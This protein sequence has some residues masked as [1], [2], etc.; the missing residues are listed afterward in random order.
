MFFQILCRHILHIADQVGS[1]LSQ[2]IGTYLHVCEHHSRN[3]QK[4]FLPLLL[5]LHFFRE[6]SQ[7]NLHIQD[8]RYCGQWYEAVLPYPGSSKLVPYGFFIHLQKLRDPL[9]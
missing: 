9:Q 8:L 2:R 5:L 3:R 4:L 1:R 7:K 6:S